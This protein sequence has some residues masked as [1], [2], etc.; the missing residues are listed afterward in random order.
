MR[1]QT[2]WQRLSRAV[3]G[4]Y[5]V[6]GSLIVALLVMAA[7]LGP[8]LAPHD[9]YLVERLQWIEGELHK[10]PFSPGDLYPLGT[11]DLGRDQLSLLLYGART[12]LVMA[13]VATVARMLLGLIV[14]TLAG[15]WPGGF[16]DRAM[17]AVTDFLAAIP[18]LILAMLLVF[19][20]GIQLGQIAFVVALSLVGW[21]E[22][23]QIVRGHV[24]TIRNKLYIMAARSLGLGPLSVLSRHVLPN[25]LATFVA[26]AALEM[27]RVLLLLGELGFV[28]VFVGGGRVGYEMATYETRHYFDVPDWGA[29]LGTSWRWFRS[30]PWY[31]LAPALAFFVSILGFNLF[32]YGLQRFVERG[33]FHPSGWSVV[34]FLLVTALVLLGARALLRSSGIEAHFAR[35]V[36]QF[37]ADRALSDIAYLARPEL[38]GRPAGSPG[39]REAADYIVS[40]FERAGLSPITRDGSYLQNYTAVRGRVTAKPTLELLTVDGTSRLELVDGV[41]LDPLQAFNAEGPTEMELVVLDSGDRSRVL[42]LSGQ[43]LLLLDGEAEVY[44]SWTGSPEYGAIVRVVPDGELTPSDEAPTFDLNAYSTLERLPDFPNLLIGESAAEKLLAEA[45]LSL[46]ELQASVE[47]GEEVKLYADLRVRLTYGLV[48]EEV[49]ATNV[50]GYIAGMDRTNQAER[51]LV[52]ASYTGQPPRGGTAFGGADE[53]ASGVAVMLETARLLHDLGTVPKRT[54]AF[55]ALD[56]VGGSYF[57]GAPALPTR[58]SNTWTTVILHG[59][60]AGEPRLARLEVGSGFSRAFDQSARRFGVRTQEL[61]EWQFFFVS[62][63]SRLAWGDPTTPNSYQGLAVSRLGDDLS[64]TPGDNPGHIDPQLLEE[65]GL[66]VAHYVLVLSSR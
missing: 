9:P 13:F 66:S 5:F 7:V 40:Q 35:Q 10:A 1:G 2:F 28:T 4:G 19:A 57:V 30:Y 60:A 56:E 38:E 48:Y 12:T 15:W 8:E 25:L 11:D 59:L 26:L 32:G 17:S 39:A 3:R 45:G 36:R 46:E 51:I 63:Y 58:P 55:A 62:G 20:V 33:R 16:F 24:L 31:P 34:R 50:I 53:N 21:G 6:A 61:D 54:V 27:G 47:E 43:A 18:G 41:S 29:M 42:G 65:A 49:P 22:V 64:G 44:R 52:A 14:G 23:A 37:D